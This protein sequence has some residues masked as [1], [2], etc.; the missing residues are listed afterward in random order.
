MIKDI[1]QL[2]KYH[3]E[4]S[5]S[6]GLISQYKLSELQK[7]CP[8]SKC[9]HAKNKHVEESVCAIKIQSVGNYALKVFFTSGCSR[10]IYTYD[11][12]KKIGLKC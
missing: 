10:G 1:K 5:W 2:D 8:C 7:C 9:F 12:L 6:D 11:L 4:I 3:F